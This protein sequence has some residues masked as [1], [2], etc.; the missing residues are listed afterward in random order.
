MGTVMGYMLQVAIIMTILYLVYKLLLAGMSFHSFNRKIIL[1]I[2]TLSW[3]LPALTDLLPQSV[4]PAAIEV[5]ALEITDVAGIA[6]TPVKKFDW[7]STLAFIYFLGILILTA[8]TFLSLWRMAWIIR[9]GRKLESSGYILKVSDKA[10]GPFSWGKYIIVRPS[11]VDE[12]LPLV[13]AHETAHLRKYHWIDLIPARIT[14]I[15]QWFSPASWLLARELHEVHEFEVDK[16]ASKENLY[17]YQLMLIKK[18][19]GSRF[20]VFADSLNHSQIKKRLTMMRKKSNPKRRVAATALLLAA[21]AAVLLLNQPAIAR[22][23]DRL[24]TAELPVFDGDKVS[25]N[26]QNLQ[27]SGPKAESS[28]LSVSTSQFNIRNSAD[29]V[30]SNDLIAADD[31]SATEEKQDDASKLT[32][33]VDGKEYRGPVSNIDPSTIASMQIVKNDPAYPDGKIMINTKSADSSNGKSPVASEK[34]AEFKGGE[35]ELLAFL[36]ENIK[37][38]ATGAEISDNP[39]RVVVSFN[40]LTDGAVDDIMVRKSGGEAFDAEAVEVVAKTSGKWEPAEE[41]GKPV[42]SQFTLPITF[43]TKP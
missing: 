25:E 3:I 7:L 41:N 34:M 36:I 39:I 12:S 14:V 33:F 31:N 27:I 17:E 43:K 5:G 42:V 4:A 22:V 1:G 32:Y 19:A 38:P 40:I 13:L 23:V 35:K 2:Y 9:R 8:A 29:E 15:L 21:F 26:D 18:T 37:Y 28:A 20:P 24:S 11:D 10:P 30:I 16:D 6:E